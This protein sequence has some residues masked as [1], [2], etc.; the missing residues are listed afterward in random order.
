MAEHS[1]CV[2]AAVGEFVER[3]EETI[4]FRTIP[5]ESDFQDEAF[6]SPN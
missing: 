6:A 1:I 5:K 4:P 2:A 3:A